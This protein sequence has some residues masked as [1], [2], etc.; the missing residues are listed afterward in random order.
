MVKGSDGGRVKPNFTVPMRGLKLQVPSNYDTE[1]RTY[2]GEW[3]GNFKVEWTDN[4]A[5]I[6]YDLITNSRLFR[7]YILVATIAL[8]KWRFYRM[9]QWCDEGKSTSP[10]FTVNVVIANH[11]ESRTAAIDIAQHLGFVE[12]AEA[13]AKG[14][15]PG[16]K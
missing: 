16:W 4:P 11:E 3:D 10:R 9:A 14:W 13:L 6:L 7:L 8:D 12:I 1:T 5:W 2:N 15:P